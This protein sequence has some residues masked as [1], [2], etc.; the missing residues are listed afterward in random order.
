MNININEQIPDKYFFDT[1]YFELLLVLGS[2]QNSDFQSQFSMSKII[3]I[4]LKKI[5]S[6][7][8]ILGAHFL[9]L[10]FLEKF[11]FW[12]TL[13]THLLNVL[14]DHWDPPQP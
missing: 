11:N 6:N 13:F 2:L 1:N 9:L 14:V 3:R 5:S 4:F 10:T 7:N 12:S 8:I